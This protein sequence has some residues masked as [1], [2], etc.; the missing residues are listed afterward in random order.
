M[1]RVIFIFLDGVGIGDCSAHNPF[2]LCRPGYLPFFSGN[3]GWPDKTPVKPIDPLLG[4]AGFPQSATG[5]TT[6]YTGVSIPGMINMHRG[7]YPDK[8]M[9]KIIKNHSLLFQL[10]KKSVPAAFINAYPV[11][12]RLFTSE[13][14][15]ILNDGRMHFSNEF[16]EL[17]KKRISVTTCM[18]V[19]AGQQPFGETDIIK[20]KTIYQDY[21]NRS[22]RERGLTL[23]EFSP[24][25]AAKIIYKKSREYAFILYEYFQTDV[26]G[27]R[28]SMVERIDL[29]EKLNRLLKALVSRLDRETDTLVITSDHGNLEDGSTRGHTLNPV[30]LITWGRE[31]GHIRKKIES[32]DQITP[33]II[34]L[35]SPR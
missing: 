4:V 32:I 15:R 10:K 21:T 14:I 22:L 23:P 6:L 7:S 35:F 16:P 11:Y 17:F 27:H 8:V 29:I 2:Y 30:P 20:E 12:T 33:A 3:Q 24:E 1:P 26:Y 28:K 5:Q 18:L 25:K 9:R 19:S 34:D 13:H 31:S